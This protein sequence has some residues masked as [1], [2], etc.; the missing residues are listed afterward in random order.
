MTMCRPPL[1]TDWHCSLSLS[2]LSLSFFCAKVQ[3]EEE[4][5]EEEEEAKAV[6]LRPRRAIFSSSDGR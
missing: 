2:I 5:E 1:S 3:E 6:F 4:E